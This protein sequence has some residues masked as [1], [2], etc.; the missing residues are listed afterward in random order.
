MTQ[1]FH[2]AEQILAQSLPS[3]ESRPQQQALA[4]A[5]EQALESG[6]HL[7]A[8]AGCGT[9]KSFG[10]SIPAILHVANTNKSNPK[11]KAK[12]VI[13]TATKALQNQLVDGDLPFLKEHLDV[14]FSFALLK[15]RSNYICQAKLAESDN[16]QLAKTILNE[17]GEEFFK[18]MTKDFSGDVESLSVSLTPQQRAAITISSDECPGA[19]Q[20]PFGSVCFSEK[21]KAK[22]ADADVVVVNHALYFTDMIVKDKTNGAASLLPEHSIVIFD[23]AHEIEEIAGNMLGA[24]V[25][26]AGIRHLTSIVRSF[27]SDVYLNVDSEINKVLDVSPRLFE[28]LEDILSLERVDTLRLRPAHL[29]SSQDLWVGVL[30][31]LH[32]L[33]EKVAQ[34]S[35]GGDRTVERKQQSVLRRIHG[36]IEKFTA[37][38]S[39]PFEDTVRWIEFEWVG[40][41]GK[42]TKRLA[43]N[44]APIN[45]GH[46]LRARLWDY[47]D[48][49]TGKPG[50]VA[51]LA[52][53]T[54]SVNRSFQYIT[55]R[56]GL[57]SYQSID[58]GTPFDFAKQSGL[59]IPSG[60]VMV[61]PTPA[62]RSRWSGQ[63][64]AQ[65]LDLIRMSKGG[66]LVLFSSVKE[67]NA[68]YEACS[69]VLPY[70]CF[71]QGQPG[72]SRA[73]LAKAFKS[74]EDSCLFATKSFFTG[75]DFQGNTCR[76]VIIDKLP[77]PVP[78]DALYAARVEA[79]E[80]QLGNSY[81]A[82]VQYTVAGMTLTLKQGFGRLIRHRNDTGVVAI[83][84]P[85]LYSKSYGKAIV[86]SLPD[87][88]RLETLAD[89]R[90][91]F[92]A[93]T[94]VG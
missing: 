50:P 61:D 9:G 42:Q 32:A 49:D 92:D 59:Y 74:D 16:A 8:E 1:T 73:D 63:A 26:E 5:I 12:A 10:Y 6:Q 77:F 41:A 82:F 13:T 30:T 86:S 19:R 44:F 75:V 2:E 67:M 17:V 36:L 68:A 23:E 18:D 21:A 89:V 78:T 52:S 90:E 70:A 29:T 28:A 24:K 53:A 40:H 71:Y 80:K 15:G 54:L 83:L 87:A 35:V 66:A 4:T 84:D 55:G 94:P 57:D 64:Q 85:R 34:H 14:D 79:V 38:T 22:A 81:K 48:A 3:Y 60:S 7:V 51:V 69:A 39:D 37:I 27:A 11:V 33:Y 91:R 72:F 47:V 76:L 93:L 88:A 43:I 31:S 62:N 25:A 58:V 20:C 45:V 56:L 65:I 46:Y